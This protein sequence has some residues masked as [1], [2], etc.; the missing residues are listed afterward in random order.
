MQTRIKKT[1]K[2]LAPGSSLK[3]RVVYALAI[4]RLIL[5]PVIF[6]TIYYLFEM[7]TIVNRIVNVDA[8]ATTLAEQVSVEML[9]ARRSER[10]YFLLNDPSYMQANRQATS[11]I[12][13]LIAQI[14][15][16]EPTERNAGQEVLK[17]LEL[18]EQQSAAAVALLEKPGGTTTQ[19]VQQAVAAYETD[20]NDLLRRSRRTGNAQLVQELQS[21]VQSFDTDLAKTLTQENPT[22]RLVTA[23]IQATSQQV[24]LLASQ[25][26]AQSWER[27]QR[28]HQEAR[29]LVHRA[30]WVLSIVSVITF[31]LSVWISFV[32][33]RE[34]VKPLV[35]LRDAV[36]HAASGNYPIEFELQGEGEI[37]DL[38][39]S[40]D[41]L[42]QRIR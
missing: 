17:S 12:R 15:D 33:P 13:Q 25:L 29:E 24:L 42:I 7:G 14:G 20:L 41:N 28:D 30:E 21:Q 34:V 39:R 1:F 11:R 40:I 36:N 19:R 6:L 18:Y 35:S 10:N 32:L 23:E 8:P 37:I 9:Q 3:R 5:A 4:V 22:L 2:V 27:V 26:E 31:L 16:L 38:A